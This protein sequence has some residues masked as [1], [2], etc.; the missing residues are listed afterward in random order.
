MG[1]PQYLCFAV[2]IANNYCLT[3]QLYI[4]AGHIQRNREIFNM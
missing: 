1:V 3:I 4:V 2:P